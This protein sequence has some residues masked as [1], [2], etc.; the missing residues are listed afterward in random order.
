MHDVFFTRIP[1][2]G[3]LVWAWPSLVFSKTETI[4]KHNPSFLIKSAIQS[5][6]D[7]QKM[8]TNVMYSLY[9]VTNHHFGPSL[10]YNLA[11]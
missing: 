5:E 4:V 6:Y 3:T 10:C 7:N 11:G 8:K 1:I 9:G 2:L